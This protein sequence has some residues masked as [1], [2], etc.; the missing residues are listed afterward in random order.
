LRGVARGFVGG[1][2]GWEV[3]CD[4]FGGKGYTVFS[5]KKILGREKTG[6]GSDA[7]PDRGILGALGPSRDGVSA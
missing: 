3:C 7:A 5:Q 2:W 6:V 4:R 1:F